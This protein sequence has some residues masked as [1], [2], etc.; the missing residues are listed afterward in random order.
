[1]SNFC[2]FEN[3]LI[4]VMASIGAVFLTPRHT[5]T[6]LSIIQKADEALYEAK[7]NGRNRTILHEENSLE[8]IVPAADAQEMASVRDPQPD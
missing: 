8:A 2:K 5:D 1:M 7:R 4:P 3:R 6:V